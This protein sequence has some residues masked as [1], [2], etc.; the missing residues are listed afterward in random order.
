V[1]QSQD[2]A[3]LPYTRTWAPVTFDGPAE[4]PADDHGQLLVVERAFPQPVTAA[5]IAE[6]VRSSAWCLEMH[7]VTRVVTHIAREGRRGMC[8]FIA[9]DAESVRKANA[10]AR[11]PVERVWAAYVK[12]KAD[13]PPGDPRHGN[14]RHA[15]ERD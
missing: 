11:L 14:G 8:V 9:P 12:R 13:A 5:D 1:R 2:K 6:M 7:R 4:E 15:R 10:T 3:G